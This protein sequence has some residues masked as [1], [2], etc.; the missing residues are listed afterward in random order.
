MKI[1][2]RVLVRYNRY[3]TTDESIKIID[4]ETKTCWKVENCLF[5]K[6]SGEKRPYTQ[7]ISRSIRLATD[8]DIT[9]VKLIS[10]KNKAYSL[11]REIIEKVD[12]DK[13]YD[14]IVKI[15]AILEG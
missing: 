9:R 4:G 5:Y 14:K 13:D 12:K 11:F 1:G 10:K 8:E 7:W 15:N 3:G 6:T 2:D